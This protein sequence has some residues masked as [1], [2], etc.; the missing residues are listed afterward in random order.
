M[1]PRPL[2]VALLA[3]PVALLGACADDPS[4]TPATATTLSGPDS[5]CPVEPDAV[6]AAL[7]APVE[8]DEDTATPVACTYL[9]SDTAREGGRVVVVLGR[10][11]EG[12]GITG[13]R[14]DAEAEFGPVAPVP[15]GLVSGA[16]DGWVVAAGRAVQVAAAHDRRLVT[17]AVADPTLDATAAQ[18]VAA[19]LAGQV[20]AS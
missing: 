7:G 20:L 19:T 18:A 17:V 8:L 2:L 13:A 16:D 15:P 11:D 3:A 4:A 9:A 10:L 6:A 14:A 5:G 1:R 12:G